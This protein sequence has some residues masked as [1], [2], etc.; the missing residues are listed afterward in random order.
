MGLCIC[1]CSVCLNLFLFSEEVFLTHDV[2]EWSS[3]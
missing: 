1:R 2:R 3:F